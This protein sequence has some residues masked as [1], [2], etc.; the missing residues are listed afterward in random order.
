MVKKR[1]LRKERI[2]RKSIVTLGICI[3]FAILS[4]GPALAADNTSTGTHNITERVGIAEATPL[5]MLHMTS[6]ATDMGI[7]F[8]SSQ[9]ITDIFADGDDLVYRIG[10]VGYVAFRGSSKN[11]GFGIFNPQRRIHLHDGSG[12]GVFFRVSNNEGAVDFG[13]DN[14]DMQFVAGGAL[15]MSIFDTTGFVAVGNHTAT[16][17]LDVVG[18]CKISGTMDVGDEATV[19]VLEITG[20]LDLAEKFPVKEEASANR[21]EMQDLLLGHGAQNKD[22]K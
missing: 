19:K 14:G 15:R 7:R 9:G 8:D 20:G 22:E 18:N 12:V 21:T 2:M 13:A 6:E 3:C 16:E 10:G 17:K 11:V 4:A 1:N 5:K